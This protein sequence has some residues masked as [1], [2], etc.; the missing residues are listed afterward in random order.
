MSHATS[1]LLVE[2]QDDSRRA[3]TLVL[4]WAGYEVHEAATV[5]EGI[6]KVDGQTVALL[7]F[8][9]PDG[10]GTELFKHI[11]AEHHY[12]RVAFMTASTH[13]AL[14]H[15]LA[16]VRPDAVFVKPIDVRRV[17]DWIEHQQQGKFN[18]VWQG[19]PRPRSTRQVRPAWRRVSGSPR[20]AHEFDPLIGQMRSVLPQACGR[21]LPA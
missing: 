11:R 9:L 14:R 2:D 15:E 4:Q 19:W 5:A 1:I 17:L 10:L 7:D 16:G 8:N 12:T 20:E 3:L 21:R 13:V 6:S 18:G